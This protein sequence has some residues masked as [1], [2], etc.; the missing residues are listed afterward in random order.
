MDMATTRTAPDSTYKIY[1]A[2]FALEEDIITPEDSLI[3]WNYEDY[4]LKYG[5]RI[6]LY[7]Q[8]CPVL[9]IGILR[10]LMIRS[11]KM[12]FNPTYRKS[13]TEIRILPPIYP[14][15]GWSPP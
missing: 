9:L 14:L 1:D 11:A 12:G 10:L 8:Q 4:P 7:K 6:R 5:N 3:S 13:D 2:L 15:I